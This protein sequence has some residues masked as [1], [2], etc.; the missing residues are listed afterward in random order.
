M[1][2]ELRAQRN[3]TAATACATGRRRAVVLRAK[4]TLFGTLSVVPRSRRPCRVDF[5]FGAVR[6]ID[7]DLVVRPFQWK[8]SVAFLRDFNR[9]AAHNEIGMQPVELAG[10][11][12]DG[13]GDGVVDEM[14]VGDIT[15]LTV[16]LAAQPRPTSKLELNALGLLNPPL[17]ANERDA[18]VRGQDVFRRAACD[19]CHQPQ[20]TIADPIFREPSADPDYR[21]S[22][23]PA[24][25][26]PVER[27]VD[28]ARP[29][30]FD[31]T[32]DQPDN[33]VH[34]P[35]GHEVHLGAFPRDTRGG[36]VVS[37][38][39]DL[40]GHDMGPGLA[41]SID[42]TST[43]AAVFM[44]ENLWGV[45]TTAPYLH[46][47]RA[48]TLTEAILLHGGEADASRRAFIQ[49]GGGAQS[50]LI[51]FLENLVLYKAPED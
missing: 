7:S 23:F 25:Q 1:T 47:G 34:D 42:E 51:A 50:D 19:T 20:L 35:S 17:A 13:D 21:D 3:A 45:G 36:A 46:D 18:I 6:G 24:G 30:S 15:A 4:Q 8:G 37:L 12:V 48:T 33:V 27:G 43:G 11:G 2:A 44:T 26:N 16:Y 14:S 38:Y 5:D 40:R 10:D 9:G 29:I 39:G 31:L 32:A 41:E 28:P 49:L 22:V